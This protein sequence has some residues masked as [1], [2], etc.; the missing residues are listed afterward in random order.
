LLLS[1]LIAAALS[2]VALA[3]IV[4]PAEYAI[5]P[6]GI[7]EQ[8]GLKKMGQASAQ[9][10]LADNLSGNENIGKDA[11][12]VSSENTSKLKPLPL[13]NPLVHQS[14]PTAAQSETLTIKLPA[15]AQTEVKAVMQ[16]GK[17]MLYSWKVDRGQIYEDFHAHS[18][19]WE[20]KSAFV[21]YEDKNDSSGA[22]GSL[23]APFSGEHGWY[24][25]NTNKF[26][27]VITLTIQGYYDK[28]ID[29]GLSR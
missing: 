11:A 9:I 17:M 8:L 27:V 20:N 12:K 10:K 18:P 5:D 7:G 19:E 15:F 2:G 13:P 26:P 4:L 21:R 3:T 16:S 14:Q 1:V 29:Y 23:V 28:I 6:T 24:W 25:L 22:N